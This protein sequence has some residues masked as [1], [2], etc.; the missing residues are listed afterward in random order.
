MIHAIY[1]AMGNEKRHEASQTVA[2]LAKP[3]GSRWTGL[4]MRGLESVLCHA[5]FFRLS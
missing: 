4:G 5:L 3:S 1:S 2:E